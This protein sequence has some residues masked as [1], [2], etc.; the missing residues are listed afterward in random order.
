MKVV[1]RA[2]VLGLLAGAGA[3]AHAAESVTGRWA[4]DPSACPGFS[5]SD[6]QTP[7]VVTDYSV[8]WRG[9][10]CRIARVQDRRHG[11]YPGGLLGPDRRTFGAGVAAAARRQAAAALG[12]CSVRRPAALRLSRHGLE[13]A[14][15]GSIFGYPER[16]YEQQVE[17]RNC[18][19]SRAA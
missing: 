3:G 12:P 13:G 18:P 10:A 17:R 5:F 1:R 19:G 2:L 7:L 8:R 14:G 16:V 11:P 4:L 9:D 15:R 6:E